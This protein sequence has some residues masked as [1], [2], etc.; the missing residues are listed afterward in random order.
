MGMGMAMGGPWLPLIN[1]G[2]QR[3]GSVIES[4]LRNELL[5]ERV[6]ELNYVVPMPEKGP[7]RV[8]LRPLRLGIN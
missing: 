5:M 3:L 6:A 2:K 7:L 8:A 4:Q 1:V